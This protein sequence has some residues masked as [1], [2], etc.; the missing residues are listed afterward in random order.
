MNGLTISLLT[1]GL[2]IGIGFFIAALIWALPRVIGRGER[3][4]AK[5]P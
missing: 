2:A 5:T 1:Y 4:K 3:D